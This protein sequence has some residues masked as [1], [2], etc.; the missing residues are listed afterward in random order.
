MLTSNYLWDVRTVQLGLMNGARGVVKGIVY[1][2]GAAP[3]ALPLYVVVE[4]PKYRGHPLWPDHPKWVPVPPVH[5]QEKQGVKLG[6]RWRMQLPLRLA[7]CL[8]VHKS[9]GLT[10]KEGIVVDLSVST[11]NRVAA[12]APGVAFVAFT[13]VTDW[14]RMGFRIS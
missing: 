14:L 3:P 13:R 7:W 8:T 6:K 2:A 12:A 11:P 10:C 9:Q 4:F 5:Q 1:A